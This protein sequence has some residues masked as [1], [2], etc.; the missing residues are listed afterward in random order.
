MQYEH[1]VWT[2]LTYTLKN[3]TKNNLT[4]EDTFYQN[5]GVKINSSWAILVFFHFMCVVANASELFTKHFLCAMETNF[6][7]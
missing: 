4:L 1:T 3:K 2:I 5:H 7:N 6:K